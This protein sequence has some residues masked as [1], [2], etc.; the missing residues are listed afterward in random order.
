[1]ADEVNPWIGNG[2]GGAKF[3]FRKL[4]ATDGCYGLGV[5]Q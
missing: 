5:E 4:D 1:M 2:M 3:D